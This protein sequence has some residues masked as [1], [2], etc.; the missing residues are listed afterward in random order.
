VHDAITALDV[1]L[2]REPAASLTGALERRRR[3]RSR[4]RISWGRLLCR[5][6]TH[7]NRGPGAWRRSLYD[8]VPCHRPG[9]CGG[10]TG[11]VR[12]DEG[13]AA[14]EALAV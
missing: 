1:R 4:A 9:L 11:G 12:L 14:C 5:Q 13:L 8:G 6:C 3:R 10:E 2:R 7:R